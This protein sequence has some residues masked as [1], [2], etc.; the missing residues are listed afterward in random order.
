MLI[1]KT[2]ISKCFMTFFK[3]P[4]VCSPAFLS[5]SLT[6]HRHRILMPPDLYPQRGIACALWR[7]P[8]THEASSVRPPSR[9]ITQAPV[10]IFKCHDRN[11]YASKANKV[12]K[13]KIVRNNS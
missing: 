2:F 1:W 5:Y 8:F 7:L 12:H 13:E 6:I 10:S 3:E 9:D 4:G 11:I